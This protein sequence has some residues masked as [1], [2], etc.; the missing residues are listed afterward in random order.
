M[1][2]KDIVTDITDSLTFSVDPKTLWYENEA[3]LLP[4]LY[5]P[6]LS[7]PPALVLSHLRCSC[8]FSPPQ[9]LQLLFHHPS[10]C[11]VEMLESAY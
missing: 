9:A 1:T 5:R 2:K 6:P 7:P 3:P 10:S 8:S 11:E 4:P